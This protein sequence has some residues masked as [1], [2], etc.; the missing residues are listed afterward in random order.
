MNDSDLT[1][2]TD[3]IMKEKAFYFFYYL[4]LLS[5]PYPHLYLSRIPPN[6]FLS[7]VLHSK[8]NFNLS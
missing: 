6:I 1:T 7:N 2:I 8:L 5:I 3:S 4:Y